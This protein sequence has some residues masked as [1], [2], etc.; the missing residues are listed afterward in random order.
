MINILELINEK[1]CYEMVRSIRWPQ[2]VHCPQCGLHWV[3]R[4]GFNTEHRY[5]QRY[6]CKGCLKRFDDLSETVLSGHHQPVQ[7][8]MMCLYFMGLNL[9]NLQ[10]A[11]ELNLNKDDVYHMTTCLREGVCKKAQQQPIQL[12]GQVEFDEVYIIAG[13]KGDAALVRQQ[14]RP[15]RRNRLK[16]KRGR[17]TLASEKPPVFGMIERHGLLLIQ[18]LPDVQQKTIQPIIL[19]AVQKGSTVFTDEYNIY[20]KLEQWGYAHR[21]VNHSIAEFARDEDQDGFHEVHTNTLEGVWSLLRSW[22]RPHR[23]ISQTRLPLYLGFFQFVHNARK[24]GLALLPSLLSLLL[25][26]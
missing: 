7:V 24:R 15:P 13:H 1:K 12:K 16:A 25:A 11:K 10:I 18:M 26:P 21:T 2:G 6:Q 14:G 9:S 3:K 20:S 22:L 5:R 4:L 23:G 19:S 8:W 17:G